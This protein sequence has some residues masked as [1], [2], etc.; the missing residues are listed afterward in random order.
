MRRLFRCLLPEML[1]QVFAC[2]FCFRVRLRG[3]LD[4]DA[5]RHGVARIDLTAL[6]SA[7]G[8]RRRWRLAPSGAH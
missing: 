4:C 1:L 7:T 5:R 3:F 8:F 2:C 6:R